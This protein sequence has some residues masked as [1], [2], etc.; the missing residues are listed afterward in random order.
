MKRSI[1]R[2][3]SDAGRGRVLAGVRRRAR[4]R[5]VSL[6]AVL[7]V[8]GIAAAVVALAALLTFASTGH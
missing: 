3:E 8:V 5:A 4:A 2:V 6:Y 1:E 7:V